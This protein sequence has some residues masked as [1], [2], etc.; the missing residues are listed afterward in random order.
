MA[1]I[2][3]LPSTYQAAEAALRAGVPV[4]VFPGGDH[5]D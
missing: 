1:K 2:G 4:M 5:E 3:A